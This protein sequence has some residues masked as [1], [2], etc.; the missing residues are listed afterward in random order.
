[1]DSG[2]PSESFL[3]ALSDLARGDETPIVRLYI[4]SAV[5][6]LP[7][8]QRW[9]ILTGLLAQA[10]DADDHNL[11]LMYWYA[12]EPLAAVDPVRALKLAA[13][14]NIPRVLEFMVRRIGASGTPDSLDVL[15]RE[16]DSTTDD[17]TRLAILRGIRSGLRGRRQVP[18]PASWTDVSTKLA[19]SRDVETRTLASS[20]AV[21]FGDP[22]AFTRL[23]EQ[24]SATTTPI[25]Q[26]REYLATLLAAKDTKLVP[27]LQG[28]LKDATLRPEALRGLAAFDDAK[29]PALIL[30]AY[31]SL[32]P[33]EKQ[34]ALGTLSSRS[35]FA[36][37]LLAAVGTDK[38]QPIKPSDLS[39]DLIRQLRNLR[40][41]EINRR[42]N[43]VWG[44]ARE[45]A[46]DKV[47][48]IAHFKQLVESQPATEADLPL[49][50]AIFSKT[51]EKCHVLFGV[52]G[53]IGP[54]L[55]GSNRANLD[56]LLSNIVDPSAVMAREYIPSVLVTTE[57][58]VLTGLVRE[59]TA[60]SVT[61][62]TA[63]ETVVV[64]K[65]EIEEMKRSDKSM[66]PDDQLKQFKDDEVRALI[67]YLASPRQTPMLATAD[68]AATIFNSRD[69]TGW[70][71][72]PELWSVE[73]GEIVG[74]S[75][76][77]KRNEFLV[78]HL[79]C[80]DFRF[81]VQ[82]KLTPNAGNSGIQFRSEPLTGGE[83]KGYQ[84]DIGV[85]WWGKL[86]EEHGRALLWNK[87]GEAHV[88][89][90]DWNDYRIEAVGSQIRT[91]INGHP[92]VD[93]DDPDGGKRGIIALQLHSGG[94]FEVRYREFKLE[95]VP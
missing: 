56:Y 17:D 67:A 73:N 21:T 66:M 94:A 61:I 34:D 55:T 78:N 33:A 32:S 9:D 31:G 64:P 54:E 59:Q 40:D 8:E 45:T 6:R 3:A 41:D 90:D 20:L 65:G 27:V 5:Q 58:R 42:I 49:G 53:K 30:S 85:G 92:C 52:G 15:V 28:L 82:V 37:A 46:E 93:L 4:A 39:A 18:M 10:N 87:S 25:D 48:L 77:L 68:N 84:A 95:V 38:S 47:K 60:N 79:V 80:G 62:V 11:P 14:G 43:D 23:R 13:E 12:A 63:T 69:L 7:L 75:P 44:V 57:G 86:Y 19:A 83:V 88:K 36:R 89:P 70:E 22:A 76:G 24:L 2:R 16:V 91:W 74:K 72:K 26:R 35:S 71:G 29:T 51:C 50:R 81:S 1:M